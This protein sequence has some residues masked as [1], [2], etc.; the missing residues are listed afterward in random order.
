[1]RWGVI[2]AVAP[3]LRAT[4]RALH[5]R[6]QGTG[7]RAVHVAGP[8]V[9]AAAGIGAAQAACCAAGLLERFPL[10]TLVSTGFAGA[11]DREL[12]TGELLVGGTAG[13]P[14]TGDALRMA[15]AADSSARAG[16]I[17]SV[18]RVLLA[19]PERD[20]AVLR[21]GAVAVDMESA[22]LGRLAQ[23]RGLGFLC[24]KA[25][26]DTTRRPLASHYESVPRVLVEILGN[27][28]TLSAILADA[29]RARRAGR[30]LAGFFRALG[31]NL[32]G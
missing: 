15:R 11:L 21:S 20:S 10:D 25:V 32:E 26:L 14:A 9:F 1:M 6:R 30:R 23:E 8:F 18:E 16:E 29:S 5:A 24:V 27:P 12:K 22:A 13:F 3:E 31:A 7:A 19:D 17:L 4:L 2:A 28:A